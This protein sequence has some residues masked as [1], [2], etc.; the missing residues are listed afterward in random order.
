[1]TCTTT[2]SWSSCLNVLKSLFACVSGQIRETWCQLKQH[3]VSMVKLFGVGS[4]WLCPEGHCQLQ[5][6]QSVW[7]SDWHRHPNFRMPPRNLGFLNNERPWA[8][9]THDVG[10]IWVL[11]TRWECLFCPFDPWKW[12]K[13]GSRMCVLFSH[14]IIHTHL[15]GNLCPYLAQKLQFSWNNLITQGTPK[16]HHSRSKGP[17]GFAQKSWHSEGPARLRSRLDIMCVGKSCL[18]K[19][20]CSWI[21]GVPW[22]ARGEN[23]NI[24]RKRNISIYIYIS[25]FWA[26]L[27]KVGAWH[28]GGVRDRLHPRQAAEGGVP[29]QKIF[30]QQ[31][32]P[33]PSEGGRK[34][35][36]YPS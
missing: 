16:G 26:I 27:H 6:S 36:V 24:F 28:E 20:T 17:H 21:G 4:I 31:R 9:D 30:Q 25:K 7:E 13:V 22:Y 14:R 15:E 19:K 29:D 18:I 11:F 32:I 10:K 34:I 5:A 3:G 35:G 1:M 2:W 8:M 12:W 33:N 23:M